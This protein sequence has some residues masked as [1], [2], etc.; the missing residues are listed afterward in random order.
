MFFPQKNSP[1]HPS[2]ITVDQFR[3]F[4]A[5]GAIKEVRLCAVG[6]GFAMLIDLKSGPTWLNTEKGNKRRIFARAE[7]AFRLVQEAG[8]VG[9]AGVDLSGWSPK[10]NT[11]DGLSRC[12]G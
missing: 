2:S 9:L 6:R 7:T 3:V 1:F 11:R 4:A 12:V 5:Q 10:M 8:L